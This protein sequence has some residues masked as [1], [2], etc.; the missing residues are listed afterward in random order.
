[1]VEYIYD[2]IRATANTDTQIAA[3]ITDEEGAAITEGCSLVLS[4][5][6]G[7]L[8]TVDGIYYENTWFFTIPADV[9]KDFRGRYWYCIHDKE[10]KRNF[11]FKQP[12]YFV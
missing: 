2:A 12:I 9:T 7:L 5:D 6:K 10:N 3:V 1:M 8:L 4:D 11:S